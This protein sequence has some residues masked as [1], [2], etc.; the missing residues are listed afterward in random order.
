MSP[1]SV[2]AAPGKRSSPP[3][4]SPIAGMVNRFGKV[5]DGTTVTDYRRRG[6]RAE[7][8]AVGEPGLRRVE[9]A[10]DQPHRHARHRQLS[11]R[12]RAA[13]QVAD[14][15]LVVVDAVVGRDGADREGVGGQPT[16][17][18]CRA[19]SCSTAST[20]SAPASNARCV[21]ARSRATARSFRF[22]CRSARRRASR[23]SSIW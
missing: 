19:S 12:R 20:A 13:L 8:H 18:G 4:S 17:S 9:Q 16:S 2:T 15:A 22:S 7:A 23:A 1:S 5:D 3:P 10:Q 14:A 11:R 21:A 6:D